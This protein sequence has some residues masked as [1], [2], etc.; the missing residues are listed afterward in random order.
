MLKTGTD[1]RRLWRPLIG[2]VVAYAVAAQS[3]LIA[4]GGF[5]LVAP[6]DNTVAFELCIHDAQGAPAAGWRSGPSRL[7]SL[8]LLLR[9]IASCGD[10]LA[11][12]FV[13]ARRCRIRRRRAARRGANPTAAHRS[14]DREP[15]RSSASRVTPAALAPP[16]ISDTSEKSHPFGH[17]G[18]N[19]ARETRRSRRAE[20]HTS[21]PLH[22][23]RTCRNS[24]T[25]SRP[26]RHS[27][28]LAAYL[29]AL[30]LARHF[31]RQCRRMAMP[32]KAPPAPAYNWSGCYAGANLGGGTSGTNFGSTVDP[33]TYLGAGDAAT[34]SGS[35]NGGANADGIL[36]GGQVGCNMQSGTLVYG[37]EGDFDYFRSNPNFNNNTNTLANGS[38]FT[39]GQSLTTNLSGDGASADRHRRRP[40]FCLRHRRRGVHQRELHGEL[41]GHQ[42][43]RPGAGTATASKSLWVGPRAPAGNTPWPTIGRSRPNICS[44]AF[45]PRVRSA[46][47][48][49][50]AAPIRCTA[51]SDLVIQLVR[52]GVNFKF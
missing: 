7:Q 45:R 10:R 39:I 32:M 22:G 14:F 6:A 19:S 26:R 17:D 28:W 35:S 25:S 38:A 27:L 51:P 36:G 8:H 41:Y 37:L 48:P 13:P 9:R 52:A 21:K 11:A 50:P 31:S 23:D 5:Q 46:R 30:P 1:S 12:G 49:A 33:G 42:S 40:Q 2:I 29:F 18:Q 4:I 43:R 24:L 16:P 44:R 3:L 47:S 34:V 15:A 20:T